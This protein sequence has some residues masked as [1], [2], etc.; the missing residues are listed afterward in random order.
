MSNMWSG[1]MGSNNRNATFKQLP[2]PK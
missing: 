1:L 2:R